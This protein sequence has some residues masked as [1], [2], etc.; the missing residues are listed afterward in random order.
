[1]VEGCLHALDQPHAILC[2]N[3]A[4]TKLGARPAKVLKVVLL[5]TMLAEAQIQ[6]IGAYVKRDRSRLDSERTAHEIV[7]IMYVA[8]GR[9]DDIL[10]HGSVAPDP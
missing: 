4:T 3:A 5:E 6:R 7:S 8:S 10:S 2:T 1:M 9:A